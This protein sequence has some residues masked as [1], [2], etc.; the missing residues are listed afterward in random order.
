MQTSINDRDLEEAT[1]AILDMNPQQQ[2]AATLEKR[3]AESEARFNKLLAQSKDTISKLI[4]QAKIREEKLKAGTT[5]EIKKYSET[6]MK[7]NQQIKKLQDMY[8]ELKQKQS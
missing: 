4:A 8:L 7:L 5:A 2:Q 6:I 3:L 1:M